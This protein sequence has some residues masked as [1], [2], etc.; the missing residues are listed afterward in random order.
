MD[1]GVDEAGDDVAVG[2]V[3]HLRGRRAPSSAPDLG[4]H[5]VEQRRRRPGTA[6][7]P[8][9][10]ITQPFLRIRSKFTR[11]RS[12]GSVFDRSASSAGGRRHSMRGVEAPPEVPAGDRP[13]RP[14]GLGQGAAVAR[15]WAARPARGG[16]GA[17]TRTPRSPTGRTSGRFRAKIRNISAV[18]TPIPLIAVRLRDDRL[19]VPVVELVERDAP[20][21]G[22]PRPGSGRTGP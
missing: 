12:L 2:D 10:S 19:V 9:P 15:A 18:Q 22:P 16:R 8:E 3:E 7:P 14:P 21:R 13:V 6:G 11:G 20:R 17:P 1:V 4:D 5:R